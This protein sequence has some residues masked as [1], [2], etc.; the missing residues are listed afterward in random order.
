MAITAY[1][2]S[3]LYSTVKNISGGTKKFGFLAASW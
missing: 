2:L 3:C 1:D